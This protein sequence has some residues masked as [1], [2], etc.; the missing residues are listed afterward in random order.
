M[1]GKMTGGKNI[2]MTYLKLSSCIIFCKKIS[3]KNSDINF[4]LDFKGNNLAYKSSEMYW[5]VELS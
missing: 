2:K 1:T 4:W 5:K 3:Q